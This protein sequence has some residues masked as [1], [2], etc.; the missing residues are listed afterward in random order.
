MFSPL[1]ITEL[2]KPQ[3]MYTANSTKQIFGMYNVI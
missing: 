1:F 3:D 2:F